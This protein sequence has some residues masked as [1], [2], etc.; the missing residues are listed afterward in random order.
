M[1]LAGLAGFTLFHPFFSIKKQ[2]IIGLQR[3]D[4][5]EF[6]A[7]VFGMMDYRRLFFLPGNNYFMADI[8]ELA[9]I[10]QDRF[11]LESISIK[12][13]FPNTLNIQLEEKISTLIYDNGETY[14]YLDLNGK[15]VEILRKVG[16]NEWREISRIA[17]S[18]QPAGEET[19]ENKITEKI[20]QPALNAI[21]S[22]LGDY[23]LVY[24]KRGLKAA[25]NDQVLRAPTIQ[26][27]IAWFNLINKRTDIPFGYIIIDNELGEAEIITRE[28]WF[29][30]VRIAE[31]QET[32]FAELQYLLREKI[33]RPGL[34]YIDLRF[35][36]RVYWQ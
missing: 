24:D 17:T 11:P 21:I 27:L 8:E 9:A 34:N 5:N 35:P 6:K 4:E 20:H 19:P 36:G 32:Q 3:I 31:N 28:G 23:P 29:L 25:V 33:Q 10:S 12:K 2:N 26:G 30:L 1:S 18:T 16:D 15:I 22:E 14:S 13:F 7:A